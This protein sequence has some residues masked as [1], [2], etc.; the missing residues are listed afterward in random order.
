VNFSGRNG[1]QLNL[2]FGRESVNLTE[3]THFR[4]EMDADATST[5]AVFDG[6]V[7]VQSPSGIVE[8]AKKKEATF[9]NDTYELAKLDKEP[10]DEIDKPQNEYH[11]RY[12][13]KASSNVSP[14]SYGV[15]DLYYYGN[16][17]N[18][19]GYG[20]MWQ[21]YFA[22]AGWDPFMDGA[23]LYSAGYGYGWVSSYPWGWVPYHSGQWMFVNGYGWAW[24]PSGS[25]LGWSNMPRVGNPPQ[26]FATPQPP[27]TPGR[28]VLVRRGPTNMTQ[29]GSGE[30]VIS[31]G[32]AGLGIPRG[33]IRNMNHVSQ[34]VS[35][36]GA[37]MLRST[38]GQTM[39]GQ[40]MPGAQGTRS[41]VNNAGAPAS[42]GRTAQPSSI[43]N[44]GPRMGG[45]G[46]SSRPAPMPRSSSPGSRPR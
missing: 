2:K 33:S 28:T 46:M 13:A 31:R 30:V 38:P 12:L 8:V 5:L 45:G 27:P 22:G 7:S 20:M 24:Q 40:P 26:R 11:E 37:V 9:K 23:W 29:R 6:K 15:S 25:W 16:F 39:A 41:A 19:P 14:Y 21:P 17:F 18:V 34:E 43:Q 32:S 4:V 1:D 10:L 3:A 42:H 35:K 44:S 36:H